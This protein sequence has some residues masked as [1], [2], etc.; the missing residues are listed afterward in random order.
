LLLGFLALFSPTIITG[1]SFIIIMAE[2]CTWRLFAWGSNLAQRNKTTTVNENKRLGE[3]CLIQRKLPTSCCGNVVS[4][5]PPWWWW[6]W[7][8]WWW[9]QFDCFVVYCYMEVTPIVIF[10]L[11]IHL[12]SMNV[13]QTLGD[14]VIHPFSYESKK[15]IR[16]PCLGGGH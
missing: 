16:K 7:W 8:W 3:S 11:I 2:R 15:M 10:K 12:F 4:L 5:F 1:I 14:H 9:L 13:K 6:W